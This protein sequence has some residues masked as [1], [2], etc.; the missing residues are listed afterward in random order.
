MGAV[1]PTLLILPDDTIGTIYACLADDIESRKALRQSCSTLHRSRAINAQ[2][3]SF[4][5]A[6]TRDVQ[7]I[8]SAFPKHATLKTLELTGISF[9]K[10]LLQK[11]LSNPRLMERLSTVVEIRLVGCE[12]KEGAATL[13]PKIFSGL[14][15]LHIVDCS[16]S[17][18]FLVGIQDP[19]ELHSLKVAGT[20]SVL[21][22][23]ILQ[24]IPRFECLQ[25]LEVSTFSSKTAKVDVNM[26]GSLY[27][28]KKLIL[29]DFGER[30]EF[31]HA[32]SLLTSLQQL[33][34]LHISGGLPSLQN[35]CSTL[36]ILRVGKVYVS[37]PALAFEYLPNLKSFDFCGIVLDGASHSIVGKVKDLVEW[38][39][40]GPCRAYAVND[41]EGFSLEGI[42]G[43]F[44]SSTCTSV[45]AAL[46]PLRICMS[47]IEY[48]K[49]IDFNLNA[50]GW[51]E[52]GALFKNA[53]YLQGIDV[54]FD[55]NVGLVNAV[56]AL[57]HLKK[58]E[59]CNES[60]KVIP[61]DLFAALIHAQ[62]VSSP[63][64]IIID[65]FEKDEA[66]EA[67]EEV[68]KKQW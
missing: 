49:V 54:E 57:Q 44:E 35:A 56:Q 5:L 18:Q 4:T 25:S 27:Q 19:R 58:I 36:V 47:S 3:H 6:E 21:V 68:L 24:A 41:E 32:D 14:R 33:S 37:M 55:N 46:E 10:P 28:L 65:S 39:S 61:D 34:C 59:L 9:D 29:F 26:L 16:S 2:I 52:M 12:L 15:A 64:D 42:E 53:S 22:T 20:E 45:L 48:I 43:E 23:S 31:I 1:E 38:L 30:I 63:L 11:C 60:I 50:E 62:L 8:T 67:Q 13:M 51:K 66:Q 17:C 7:S 40:K